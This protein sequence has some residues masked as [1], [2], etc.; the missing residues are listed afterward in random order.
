MIKKACIDLS[1]RHLKIV[2][3]ISKPYQ[4]VSD[5]YFPFSKVSIIIMCI[6]A[7]CF[8][9]ELVRAVACAVTEL[10]VHY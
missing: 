10:T 9:Q 5:A 2:Q 6:I 8:L 7:S 4:F 1:K 3:Q